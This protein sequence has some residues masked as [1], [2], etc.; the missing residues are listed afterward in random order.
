VPVA[1]GAAQHSTA[2]AQ[3]VSPRTDFESQALALAAASVADRE[4]GGDGGGAG[5]GSLALTASTTLTT[6]STL[7][8]ASATAAR[9]SRLSS[10]LEVSVSPSTGHVAMLRASGVVSVWTASGDT[11][12]CEFHVLGDDAAGGALLD[13]PADVIIMGRPC[14]FAE[15]SDDD[16]RGVD[17]LVLNL[18]FA[19]RGFEW[20]DSWQYG[21]I[22]RLALRAPSTPMAS[23]VQLPGSRVDHA[24][25]V[26]TTVAT[27]EFTSLSAVRMRL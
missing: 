12:V 11:M 22:A 16:G 26:P 14:T 6:A 10:V 15:Q 20:R 8:A 19:G 18:T 9:L 1:I 4:R 5:G 13:L 23:D 21:T 27:R 7:T 2:S 25:T 24:D 17:A 3:G